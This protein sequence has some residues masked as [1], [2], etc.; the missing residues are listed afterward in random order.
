M[1]AIFLFYNKTYG[2]QNWLS[3]NKN[4]K[5]C[6]VITY[7]GRDWVMTSFNNLGIN[8]RVVK[9]NNS[10]GLIKRMKTFSDNMSA[11]VVANIKERKVNRWFPFGINSCN[12][13]CR[14]S[15]GI[16][17]GLTL[18]VAHFY[19][20]LIMLDGLTNYEIDYFWRKS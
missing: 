20:K 16:D 5:H 15:S 8:N 18:N 1:I 19:H 17:C 11:I 4:L 12:E 7:D 10:E 3:F 14:I 13:I 9:I 6:N 2:I